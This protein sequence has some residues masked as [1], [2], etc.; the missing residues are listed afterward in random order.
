[1]LKKVLL[2]FL[3]L[4]V[5]F[6]SLIAPVAKAE[7]EWYDQSFQQWNEKVFDTDN[8]DEIFGE[9]YTRAQVQWIIYSLASFTLSTVNP[10][11]N[12]IISCITSKALDQCTDTVKTLLTYNQS[13]PEDNNTNVFAIIFSQERPISAI[14]YTK[15]VARH[16]HIIPEVQAQTTSG[17]GFQ[18]LNPV[19]EIW[20]VVRN[21]TYVLLTIVILV[22]AFMIMF[23]VKINPQTVIT[24]QSALPKVVFALILITFSYAIAGLLVDLMY[25]VIGIFSLLVS[26]SLQ[27]AIHVTL[28]VP[29]SFSNLINGPLNLGI[30]GY[31][32]MYW[33]GFLFTGAIIAFSSTS[34]FSTIQIGV[35]TVFMFLALIIVLIFIGL[36]IT[37][38]L[39]KALATVLLQ[40]II[41]PIQI[42]FGAV[43]PNMGFSAWLRSYLSNLAV[44]PVT[45]L[46]LYLAN[47]FLLLAFTNSVQNLLDP[48]TVLNVVGSLFPFVTAPIGATE[49]LFNLASRGGWPPLLN[50]GDETI[51][52]VFLMTSFVIITIIP[53]SVELIKSI[54]KGAEFG[55]G[56]AINEAVGP[57]RVVGQGALQR[58]VSTT[59]RAGAQAAAGRYQYVPPAH[60]QLLKT[61]GLAK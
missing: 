10:D 7:G 31:L 44:F 47:Y 38:M 35:F 28:N 13:L 46:L 57:A 1:M 4:I 33:L 22:M 5:V 52:L 23:R 32:F 17:F 2:V 11:A 9:R 6:S 34:V 50:V 3:G 58:Y 54:I 59:E 24:V 45:G 14:T 36:K 12:K 55:Y 43:S 25:V 53:K 26:Q 15:D 39:F 41:A 42:L 51:P 48:G 29:A 20:K 61:L 30:F 27:Q 21:L 60:I 8:P 19:L 40:T 37:W 16:L 18:A 49:G 56:Q